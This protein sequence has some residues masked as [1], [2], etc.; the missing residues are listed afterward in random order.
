MIYNKTKFLS[1]IQPDS[2]WV[3]VWAMYGIVGFTI[4]ICMMM[5]ILGKCCG[6]VWR[7]KDEGLKVK[8]IALTSG[9]AGI[10]ICSYGNEVINTMPSLIVIYVSIVFVYIMPKLE[11]EIIDRDLKTQPI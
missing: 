2:Y 8:A 1:K 6:I 3:K 11:Q 5:Y 4:W 7:I 9:F 10:L